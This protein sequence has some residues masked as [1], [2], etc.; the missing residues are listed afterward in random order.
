MAI[1]LYESNKLWDGGKRGSSS[2]LDL[3]EP[4]LQVVMTTRALHLRS[5]PGQSSLPGGKID[6]S[7]SCIEE[8]AL[9]ESEE[10]IGLDRKL[11]GK[12]VFW[13]QT[14]EPCEHS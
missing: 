6:R 3:G 14:R 5:H 10:E 9:R 4:M 11:L 8:A 13:L 12:K 7:D 1:I 2:S